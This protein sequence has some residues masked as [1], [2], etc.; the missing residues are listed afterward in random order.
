MDSLKR[1]AFSLSFSASFEGLAAFSADA[2][3]M[4]LKIPVIDELCQHILLK[5]GNRTGLKTH[6]LL[7]FSN[8]R[9]GQ[10]H[11]PNSHGGRNG[12]T[13]GVDIDHAAQRL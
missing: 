12:L 1:Q 6:L 7:K 3:N 2:V 5:H 8:T 10:N 9:F 13:E 4:P 11:V